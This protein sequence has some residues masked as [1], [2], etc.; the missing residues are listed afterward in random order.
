MLLALKDTA[1]YPGGRVGVPVLY[2]EALG[3]LR[4][5]QSSLRTTYKEVLRGTL[6]F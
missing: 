1:I 6:V 2:E 4:Q 5:E 3:N